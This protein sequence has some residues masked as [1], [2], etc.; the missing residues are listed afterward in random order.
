M[1]VAAIIGAMRALP[2]MMPGRLLA[3][4]NQAFAGEMREGFVTCCAA[5]FAANG[6]M[7]IANAGHLAPYRN[8]RE[9]DC[10][11]ALPVGIATG[12]EYEERAIELK[13]GETLTFLSDGVIE[14]RNSYGEL[15]GFERTAA[16][17][18]RSAGEIARAAQQFGQEDDI[19]VLT[20]T[21]VP[22]EG[23]HG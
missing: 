19:T 23:S 1:T 18:T 5:H 13:P 16:I 7:T 12:V 21:L 10:G 22:V 3:G 20:L 11:S 14:A 4:M 9:I 6:K 17:S 2:P 15:F 8:G